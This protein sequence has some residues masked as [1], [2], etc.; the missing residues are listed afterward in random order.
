MLITSLSSLLHLWHAHTLWCIGSATLLRL[1]CT[2]LEWDHRCIQYLPDPA[3]TPT[4]LL[5]HSECASIIF[6]YKRVTGVFS[7]TCFNKSPMSVLIQVVREQSKHYQCTIKTE[8]G[9]PQVVVCPVYFGICLTYTCMLVGDP[10]WLLHT[11]MCLKLRF[12]WLWK[13]LP[14]HWDELV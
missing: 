2:Y 3:W 6:K 8:S 1:S 10:F 13:Y 7:W 14:L 5:K 9:D 12:N 4:Y 11:G